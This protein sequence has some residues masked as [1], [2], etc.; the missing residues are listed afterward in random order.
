MSKS[1]TSIIIADIIADPDEDD[2]VGAND[3]TVAP[4]T[5]SRKV[6]RA[7]AR[8]LEMSFGM[9]RRHWVVILRWAGADRAASS[10]LAAI[11]CQMATGGPKVCTAITAKTWKW[12]GGCTKR[13]RRTMFA[14]LRLVPQIVRLERSHRGSNYVAHKG[15]WFDL[16]PPNSV[17]NASDETYRGYLKSSWWLA[18]R[19]RRLEAAGYRCEHADGFGRCAETERLEA[20]HKHYRSLGCEADEDLS[21]LCRRHHGVTQSLVKG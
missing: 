2:L 16:A 10:L 11:A 7:A 9:M 18:R 3:S 5:T 1:R 15:E 13:E 20:H 12:M 17:K 21:V 4:P 19:A 14:A 8:Q 6:P